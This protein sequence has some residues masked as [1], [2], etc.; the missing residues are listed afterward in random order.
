MYLFLEDDNSEHKKVKHVNRNV[1]ATISDNQYKGVLLNNKCLRHST[2]RIQS[3]D[4]KTRT[5][6]IKKILCLILMICSKQ[7]I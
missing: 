3:K 2:N 7:W 6:E 1:V 4:R 5:Y